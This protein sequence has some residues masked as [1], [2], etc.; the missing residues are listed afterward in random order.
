LELSLKVVIL[1]A[2]KGTRMKSHLPKVL[3]PVAGKPMIA[4]VIDAARGL[5]ASEIVV[6]VSGMVEVLAHTLGDPKDVT[7]ALQEEQLG[8][9]HAVL[10]AR[11]AVLKDGDCE[12]LILCG[13]IPRLRLETMKDFVGTWKKSASKAALITAVVPDPFGYGRILRNAEGGFASIVEHRD[14]SEQERKIAEINAGI[15]LAPARELFE[16][17]DGADSKNDQGEIYL[18]DG[19]ISMAEQDMGVDAI[20]MEP[21]QEFE[22]VNNRAQLAQAS[23][24]IFAHKAEELM[25]SGVTLVDPATT[26]IEDT[27]EVG[28]D[29]LIEPGVILQGATRIAESCRVGAYSVLRDTVVGDH[30]EIKEHSVVESTRIGPRA[31]VGPFA[32]LR[33]GTNLGADS[34]VGNFVETKKATLGDGAKASHLSYLGDCEIGGKSNIGAGTIT[35]NYDGFS[36][37]RTEIG[38]GVFVGSN[39]TLVAPLFL[40]KGSFVAAG[41]TVTK[42]SNEDDLVIGRSRQ[43]IKIGYAKRLRDRMCALKGKK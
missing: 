26:Y 11:E 38:E 2:G 24:W 12:I 20:P 15:Y 16:A 7:W 21:H 6:V 30:A 10:C 1:A 5:G 14:A 13:D 36:K 29:T 8:T 3:H 41:S 40:G 32:R 18:T 25:L 34:K 28:M 22:G 23:S 42:S 9:G 31:M 17:L 4:R 37:H 27:V 43:E 35:C 33:E 39:S 19:F